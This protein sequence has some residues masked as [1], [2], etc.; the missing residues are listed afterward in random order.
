[1]IHIIDIIS[2][3][4]RYEEREH[5][6]DCSTDA[7]LDEWY[8]YAD[9]LMLTSNTLTIECILNLKFRTDWT[10]DDGLSILIAFLPYKS[11]VIQAYTHFRARYETWLYNNGFE[12]DVN[13]GLLN[14]L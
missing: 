4:D 14:G 13:E 2:I 12:A 10:I 6:F 7:G 11:K 1:M 3:L 5:L 8:V 9:N